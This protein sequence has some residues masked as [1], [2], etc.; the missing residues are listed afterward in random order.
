MRTLVLGGA[1]SGKSAFAEQ[2]VGPGPVLYVATARP[3]PSDVDFAQR[4]ALH[5]Q[6]RPGSWMLDEKIDAQE[7]LQEPHSIPVLVDDLGTWLSHATEQCGPQAW[8]S[9][10]PQLDAKITTLIDAI[11]RYSGSDLVLVS[12]EVGM[13]I[14]PE[15]QSGRIFRDRIGTLNQDLAGVCERVVFVVAG[16]PLELKTL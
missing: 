1:R 4:I 8:E 10:S 16:L 11:S 13:G 7:L 15:Y 3:H 12:P 9:E 2:L 6:R 5:A 14:I